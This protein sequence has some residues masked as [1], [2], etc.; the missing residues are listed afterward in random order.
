[1][2]QLIVRNLPL[3]SSRA[4]S[5][6]QPNTGGR[7]RPNTPE[8]LKRALLGPGAAASLEALSGRS[9]TSAKTRTSFVRPRDGGVLSALRNG[10]PRQIRT[11]ARG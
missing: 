4:L 5:F 1:M 9:R 7:T 3:R 8:I 10:G 6:A 11:C 2:R